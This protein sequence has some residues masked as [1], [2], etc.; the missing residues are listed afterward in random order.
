MSKD[1][2]S[3]NKRIAKNTMLLYF[4][5]LIMMGVGLYTSRI[6][7]SALGISDYGINNVV[8]GVVTMASFLNAGLTAATQRF[9]SYELG[10]GDTDKLADVFSNSLI[11][12]G[13]IALIVFILS[14]TVGLW[15]VNNCL[16]IDANR[17]V[18]A[19]WVFQFSIFS[20]M[21]G[22]MSVPYNSAIIAHEHMN[23]FAYISIFEV[24]FKLF[25]AFCL[26]YFDVDKLILYSF[27]V[28]IISLIVRIC[29]GIYCK[30]HFPECKTRLS[31]NKTI[32]REMG[33]FSGWSMFGNL[34]FIGRD[35][36]ANV[37]LNIFMGTSLNAARGIALH[38]T[39]LVNQFSVN[40]TMA[41]N[42]QITKQFAAGELQECS[43]LVYEGAKFSFFLLTAISI[44]VIINCDY[45]LKLWLGIVPPYTSQFIILSLAVC[46]L[47]CLTQTVTVAIQA[48]KRIKTFQIGI[49]ILLISELPFVWLILLYNLPPYYIMYPQIITS[50]IAIIFRFYLLKRYVPSFEWSRYIF[51]VLIRSILVSSCCLFLSYI[52]K[53][54]LTDNLIN[55]FLSSIVSLIIT[56]LSCYLLG[57]N[58]SEKSVIN[59]Y[60]NKIVK[61]SKTDN[62]E[63]CK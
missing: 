6:V 31:I 12:H 19:N 26:V 63:I 22:I 45:L 5:M 18:A 34:G 38:V 42:P 8:G 57:L 60:I 44:P 4:R 17:M 35:Q 47:Y 7:L 25:V 56:L 21:I 52:V 58:K 28:F 41:M 50:V 32:L 24:L 53:Q 55:L 3:N 39:S 14:E 49:C 9:I 43:R 54:Q 30:R 59:N 2:I 1:S 36:G 11:V 10:R 33:S 13:A 40:F 16:N 27:L 23:A 20:F 46:L 51:G 15:F 61:R 37:I 48:T 29:Y 62:K